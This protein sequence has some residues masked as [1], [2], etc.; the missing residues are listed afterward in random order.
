MKQLPFTQFEFELYSTE[1]A[2]KLIGKTAFQIIH[3][4]TLT[5]KVKSKTGEL[6]DRNFTTLVLRKR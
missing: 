2:E 5:E 1:K 4:E 3:K 6:V